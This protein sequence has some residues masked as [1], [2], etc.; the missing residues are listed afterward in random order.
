MPF[1]AV[2]V[3]VANCF[4]LLLR[5]VAIVSQLYMYSICE[6]F[7]LYSPYVLLSPNTL[8]F[9]NQSINEMNNSMCYCYCCCHFCFIYYIWQCIW[10][11]MYAFG[12]FLFFSHFLSLKSDIRELAHRLL[13]HRRRNALMVFSVKLH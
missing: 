12:R 5:S 11:V 8:R 1:F 10:R 13:F 9:S 7:S 3:V 6:Y 4:L 2:I